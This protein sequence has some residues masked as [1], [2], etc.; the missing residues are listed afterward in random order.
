MVASLTKKMSS[1][2]HA[3]SVSKVFFKQANQTS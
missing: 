2:R 1:L 3:W